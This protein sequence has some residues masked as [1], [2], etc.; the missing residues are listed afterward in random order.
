MNHHLTASALSRAR[1]CLWWARPDV[2]LPE[3]HVG[4]EAIAGTEAHKLL[5]EANDDPETPWVGQAW[6]AIGAPNNPSIELAIAYDPVLDS[7][8]ALPTREARDYSDCTD[9]EIAG[10][11][12]AIWHDAD[13]VY[14]VDWK[15]GNPDYVEPVE[16]NAQLA[17]LAVAFSALYGVERARVALAFVGP[18]REPDVQWHELDSDAMDA[19]I[20]QFV[21]MMDMADAMPRPGHHCHW[22]PARTI[23]PAV[24]EATAE[25]A[26]PEGAALARLG[27]F[28]GALATPQD[29]ERVRLA[30]KLVRERCESLDERVKAWVR[31]HG[32]CALSNGKVL[33]FSEASRESVSLKK[34][35]AEL[36]GQLEACGA[37]TV[38]FYE[39]LR[40]CKR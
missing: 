4:P 13:C 12:D 32:E 37:V 6:R 27:P 1:H 38:S 5:A 14:V 2:V 19:W 23:C 22:C 28:E 20:E 16:D 11:A 35:P 21:L 40:E 33:R 39:T 17:F 3:Q 15:T 34:V 18:D 7:A 26:A 24:V 31:E 25:L 8:R 29:V 10:T 30:V 9:D 36:R